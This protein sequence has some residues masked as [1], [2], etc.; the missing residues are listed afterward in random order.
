MA[1]D[2][3]GRVERLAV[4]D[5]VPTGEVWRRAE[6]RF[7]IGYWHWAFLAQPAPLPERLIAGDPDA[8]FDAHVRLIG[9]GAATGRYPAEVMESYRQSLRDPG[10]VQAICE[11]Y[12]AGASIDA[13]H[14]AAEAG[15][16]KI[17]CPVLALWG[18]RGA[19]PIFYDDV[20]AIWRDWAVDVRG[21]SVDAS[22]F[23]VEDRPEQLA[24]ALGTFLT[25]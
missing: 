19:L 6:R 2:H 17:T 20:L 23:L 22:H 18:S 13:E 12:R 3:P 1:L 8:Y 16:R 14:D 11:D 10:A 15:R 25:G 9:L 5:I 7:A 4:L 24:T 21:H